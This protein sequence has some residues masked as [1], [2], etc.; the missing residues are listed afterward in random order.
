M[1]VGPAAAVGAATVVVVAVSGRQREQVLDVEV[2]GPVGCTGDGVG[3]VSACMC[4]RGRRQ[5]C[6]HHCPATIRVKKKKKEEKT[7]LV[8]FASRA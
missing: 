7:H 4:V 1:G 2:T 8:G 5:G 3:A 6:G